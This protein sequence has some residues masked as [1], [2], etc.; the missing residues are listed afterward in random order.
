MK[1]IRRSPTSLKVEYEPLEQE[2]PDVG[3]LGVDDGGQG[4]VDVGEGG[5]GRLEE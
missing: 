1:E 3:E 4:G 5:G 2:L